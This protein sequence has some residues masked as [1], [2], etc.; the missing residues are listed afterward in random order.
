MTNVLIEYN[1][2]SHMASDV[3]IIQ[4]FLPQASTWTCQ[5]K[6]KPNTNKSKY[7][8]Y[9]RMQEDFATQ[10]TIEN[11]HIDRCRSVKLLGVWICK[12]PGCWE[13]NTCEI[14][15]RTYA[16]ISTLKKM[17]YASVSQKKLLHIY[18]LFVRSSSEFDG[19]DGHFEYEEALLRL[20]H[21]SSLFSRRENRAIDFGK[22]CVKHPSLKHIFTLNTAVFKDPHSV[23]T[24]EMYHVNHCRTSVYQN[25]AIPAIQRR[26]NQYFKFPHVFCHAHSSFAD[27]NQILYK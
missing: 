7:F 23:R 24:H 1:F 16:H 12:D 19:F 5:N 8:I 6:A 10:F 14:L 13:K 22:K 21:L 9:S 25:T 4:R 2:W 18:S 3:G 20:N 17:K 11:A 27:I 26:L 15:R